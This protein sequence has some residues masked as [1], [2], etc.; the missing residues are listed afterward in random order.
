MI[1]VLLPK[2]FGKPGQ[3]GRRAI[4]R[5]A[6]EQDDVWRGFRGMQ[7]GTAQ[8]EPSGEYGKTSQ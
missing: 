5:L 6:T 2:P 3:R 1:A 7:I 8:R 4:Q